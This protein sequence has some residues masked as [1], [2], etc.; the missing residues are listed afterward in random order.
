M[1]ELIKREGGR[2]KERRQQKEVPC[3]QSSEISSKLVRQLFG[4][5]SFF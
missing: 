1:R 2:E 5:R 4:I 3:Y